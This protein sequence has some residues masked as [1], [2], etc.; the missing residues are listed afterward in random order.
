MK[1]I[2]ST[3]EL[4]ES[5]PI[6]WLGFRSRV[7]PSLCRFSGSGFSLGSAD[8]LARVLPFGS[9]D[10]SHP[11]FAT[12]FLLLARWRILRYFLVVVHRT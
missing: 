7:L 11:F 10:S 6:P 9:V 2:A 12:H 8:S 5:L 3:G 4:W 1:A